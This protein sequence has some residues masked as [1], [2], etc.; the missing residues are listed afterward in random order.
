MVITGVGIIITATGVG[1]T[2]AGTIGIGDGV[3]ITGTTGTGI[4]VIG[5]EGPGGPPVF[6]A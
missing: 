3:T 5:G 4:I 2:T 6:A 1:D